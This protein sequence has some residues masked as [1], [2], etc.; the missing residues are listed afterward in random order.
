MPEGNPANQKFI[1]ARHRKTHHPEKKSDG[2]IF[3]CK[4]GQTIKKAA[5]KVVRANMKFF[6]LNFDIKDGLKL[7]QELK[8]NV[9]GLL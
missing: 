8:Q 7:K 5:N 3:H 2:L 4:I 9:V 1:V 6:I